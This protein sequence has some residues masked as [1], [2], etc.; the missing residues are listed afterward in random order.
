MRAARSTLGLREGYGDRDR[1]RR[2]EILPKISTQALI[3][4][5]SSYGF[6][7]SNNSRSQSPKTHFNQIMVEVY[8]DS[9]SSSNNSKLEKEAAIGLIN[10]NSRRRRLSSKLSMKSLRKWI[11]DQGHLSAGSFSNSTPPLPILPKIARSYRSVVSKSSNEKRASDDESAVESTK[12]N[13]Q[14]KVP[15]RQTSISP[16]PRS[17]S[18]RPPSKNDSSNLWLGPESKNLKH[19][20]P[21]QPPSCSLNV[22]LTTYLCLFNLYSSESHSTTSLLITTHFICYERS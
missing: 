21:S 6:R 3:A 19:R 14:S 7:S 1:A 13:E 9:V 17:V 18:P 16:L 4:D 10:D 22:Y 15:S 20:S 11:R 5:S 8:D 12:S 2:H